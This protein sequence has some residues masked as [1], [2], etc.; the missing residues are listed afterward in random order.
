MS[1]KLAGF[2]A[3]LPHVTVA[4]PVITDFNMPSAVE[5]LYG[6]DYKSYNALRPFVFLSGGPFQTPDDVIIDDI[7][8]SIREGLSRRRHDVD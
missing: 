4:A 1:A 3:G 2:L 5:I 7:L 6:I 8:C